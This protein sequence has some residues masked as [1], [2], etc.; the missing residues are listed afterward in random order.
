MYDE[1]MEEEV[2]RL[3]DFPVKFEKFNLTYAE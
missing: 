3:G 1:S 2:Y